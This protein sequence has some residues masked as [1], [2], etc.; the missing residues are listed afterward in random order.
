MDGTV[1]EWAAV[2]IAAAF[3]VYCFSYR[4][5]LGQHPWLH[6]LLGGTAFLTGLRR[7]LGDVLNLW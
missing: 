3:A 7:F 1:S 4:D 5:A 2:G 6:M